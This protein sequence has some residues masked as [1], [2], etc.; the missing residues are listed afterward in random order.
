M[1]SRI[2]FS[3]P[4][5]FPTSHS[6]PELIYAAAAWATG[7]TLLANVYSIN[8]VTFLEYRYNS[9][10]SRVHFIHWQRKPLRNSAT[11]ALTQGKWAGMETRMH[12]DRYMCTDPRK[13]RD[14]FV[15]FLHNTPVCPPPLFRYHRLRPECNLKTFSLSF[16]TYPPPKF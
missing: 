5:I 15:V 11:P 4:L 2:S 10:C 16:P 13:D 12:R 6:P 8:P 14:A 1:I 7:G 3:H 9:F